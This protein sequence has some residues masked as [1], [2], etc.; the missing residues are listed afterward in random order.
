M[1][2]KNYTTHYE[3]NTICKKNDRINYKVRDEFLQTK[4]KFIN[5]LFKNEPY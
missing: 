3:T 1:Y 4:R 5:T 2:K